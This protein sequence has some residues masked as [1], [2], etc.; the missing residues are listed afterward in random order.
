MEIKSLSNKNTLN[1][2]ETPP[3]TPDLT[4]V[5]STINLPS[6]ESKTVITFK[7]SMSEGDQQEAKNLVLLNSFKIQVRDLASRQDPTA[8]YGIY[9]I[10][11]YTK[12]CEPIIDGTI[13]PT[14]DELI[15]FIQYFQSQAI[16]YNKQ[17]F[18][19]SNSSYLYFT[20]EKCQKDIDTMYQ[21]LKT[22]SN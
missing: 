20:S 22:L 4:S 18:S 12:F 13:I 9:E 3:K 14:K 11:E 6:Y 16:C 15:I 21:K 5:I 2:I 10:S 8:Y 17:D 19:S 1:K 7:L